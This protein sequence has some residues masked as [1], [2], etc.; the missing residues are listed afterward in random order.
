MKSIQIKNLDDD[1]YFRIRA[2]MARLRC[3]SY[4]E[5]LDRVVEML[6]Y[7]KAPFSAIPLEERLAAAKRLHGIVKTDLSIEEI[8][9]KS[10]TFLF[11]RAE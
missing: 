10:E 6:E 7:N 8:K 2:A 11:E 5:F 1:L 3:N 4:A 9:E